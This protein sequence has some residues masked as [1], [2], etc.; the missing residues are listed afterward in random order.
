[1]ITIYVDEILFKFLARDYGRLVV[2]LRKK[3]NL[4][5]KINS[6]NTSKFSQTIL[7]IWSLLQECIVFPNANLEVQHNNI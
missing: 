1:M 6:L 3:E 7:T 2:G 5:Q 4:Q